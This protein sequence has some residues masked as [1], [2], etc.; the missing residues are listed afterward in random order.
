MEKLRPI[1]VVV[2]DR[3]S[4]ML[5]TARL[6]LDSEDGIEVVGSADDLAWAAQV[7]ADADADV[8]VADLHMLGPSSRTKIAELRSQLPGTAI[9]ILTME[10]TPAFIPVVF[11]AGASGYVLKEFAEV[12]LAQAVRE[13]AVGHRFVSEKLAAV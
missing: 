2:A 5:S 10:A 13:A 7:A 9:V 8:L 4:A 6:L 11:E 12:D 1:R 3:H